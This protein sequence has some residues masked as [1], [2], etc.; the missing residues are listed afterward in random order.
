M[1]GVYE[2]IN[3]INKKIYVG[4]S[5]NIQK[6]ISDHWH[7]QDGSPIHRAITKYGRENFSYRILEE[8]SEEQLD[9]REA[10][11]INKENSMVPNGYNILPGGTPKP[12]LIPEVREKTKQT[13]LQ[14]YGVDVPM[15]S[16]QVKQNFKNTMKERYGVEHALQVPEIKARQQQTFQKRYGVD[17]PMQDEKM[18]IKQILSACRGGRYK[19]L[20]NIE[21]GLCFMPGEPNQWLNMS[22]FTQNISKYFKGQR[23]SCGHLSDGTKLHWEV[24]SYEEL[25]DNRPD[26]KQIMEEK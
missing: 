11:W 10:Y 19:C 18:K 5:I 24:I 17:N 25:L 2:I 8:C 9:E 3:N 4:Q 14:K 1:I 15:K 20:R 13:L 12:G 22:S 7:I 23:K 16:E 6:R 26:L 21:T